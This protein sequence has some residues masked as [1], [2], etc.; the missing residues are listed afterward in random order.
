MQVT[1]IGGGM[2]VHDQILPSLYQLQRLGTIGDITICARHASTLDALEQSETI[3]QAFPGHSFRRKVT[4]YENALESYPSRDLAI[5]A[6]P[7][8]LHFDAVMKALEANRHVIAV[9]PLVLTSIHAETIERE[10]QRRGLFVGIEYHKRFDDRSLMARRKY[11]AGQFCEFR[12]GTA[13][14]M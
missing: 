9:K 1:V 4:S 6:L 11:R 2:I 10:S 13:S 3:R 7:D 14:L 12:L 8:Q 5:V